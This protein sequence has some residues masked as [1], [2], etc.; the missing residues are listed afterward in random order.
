MQRPTSNA[1]ALP[2]KS[3]HKQFSSEPKQPPDDN[4]I[5]MDNGAYL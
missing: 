1:Q 4:R 2:E 3:S 5:K